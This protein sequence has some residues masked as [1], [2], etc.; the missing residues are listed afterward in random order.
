MNLF[1][2]A[3]GAV[4]KKRSIHREVMMLVAALR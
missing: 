1:N 4:I 2:T 3:G